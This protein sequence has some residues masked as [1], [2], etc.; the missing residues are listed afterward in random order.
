MHGA[1]TRC[2]IAL[3]AVAVVGTSTPTDA[4]MSRPAVPDGTYVP[5]TPTKPT[6]R[7]TFAPPVSRAPLRSWAGDSE[8]FSRVVADASARHGVPERLIW[9]VIR[10]ESGFDHRA[11]SR[12]GARGLMQL[13]P[14]TAAILGVRDSFDPRE[15]IHAGARHLRGLMERFRY[16]LPLAIAAYNAGEK[17]VVAFRGIPPYPE[18]RE[19]VT[20][21]LR[22]YGAPIAW[23][24]QGSGIQQIVERDGT[25]VY[26]NVAPRRFSAAVVHGR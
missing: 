20:R 15:N 26:T 18:T 11:V 6:Y 22:F 19:Y 23:E 9:A 5:S 3:A 7:R 10:V 1:G 2:L 8:A 25:V 13:M 12:R 16:D 21:V 17:P 24:L 4:E 14:E